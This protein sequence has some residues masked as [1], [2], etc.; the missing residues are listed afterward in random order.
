MPYKH[1]FLDM[2][3]TLSDSKPGIINSYIYALDHYGIKAGAET[4][5]KVIGPPLRDSFQRYFNFNESNVD[6]AIAKFRERYSVQGLLELDL[7]AGVPDML[8]K[9]KDAGKNLYIASSKSEDYLY[10]ILDRFNLSGLFTFISGADLATRRLSKTEVLLHAC[11]AQ[12]I[13]VF[14]DCVMVGDR[15]HDVHG[16]HDVGMPCIGVLYGYGSLDELQ[17]AGAD[18]IAHTVPDLEARL[19]GR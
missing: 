11:R 7:Y 10:R 8:K 16:A 15:E 2:D 6:E 3:G 5:D 12:N 17:K 19:L 14:E 18:A 1:I 13:T 4:L 9:L